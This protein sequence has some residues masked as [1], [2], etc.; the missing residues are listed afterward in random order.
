[1][2]PW[3]GEGGRSGSGVPDWMPSRLIPK[4]GL[5]LDAPGVTIGW[6]GGGIGMDDLTARTG[7]NSDT[8]LS[9]EFFGN[10]SPE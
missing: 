4:I 10:R 1:M 6:V 8:A 9:E 2:R 3:S 5:F 7:A